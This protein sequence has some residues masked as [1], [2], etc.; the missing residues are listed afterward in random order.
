MAERSLYGDGRRLPP[1]YI[2]EGRKD[3]AG[4]A[5]LLFFPHGT[6]LRRAEEPKTGAICPAEREAETGGPGTL[7]KTAEGTGRSAQLRDYE[8]AY[9]PGTLCADVWPFALHNIDRKNK[10]TDEN[11]RRGAAHVIRKNEGATADRKKIFRQRGVHS[12]Y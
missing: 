7:H 10:A 1:L 9:I 8:G 11:R 4:A 6:G 3:R 5:V 12:T 2:Y